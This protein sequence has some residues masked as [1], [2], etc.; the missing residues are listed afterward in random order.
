MRAVTLRSFALLVVMGCSRAVVQ[1]AAITG[2]A[3]SPPLAAVATPVPFNR[4]EAYAE[5]RSTAAADIREGKLKLKTYGLPFRW[6]KEYEATLKRDYGIEV[7]AVAGCIVSEPLESEVRGYNE[8]ATTRIGE[9]FG[10]GI[11]EKVAERVEDNYYRHHDGSRR[12]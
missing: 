12:R 6:A 11:L 2:P 7:V 10:R 5:G 4:A 1:P 3:V 9:R 8:V